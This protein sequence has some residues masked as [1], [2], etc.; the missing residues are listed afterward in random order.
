LSKNRKDQF[1]PLQAPRT[2]QND[3]GPGD[4]W[5][6]G[7]GRSKFPRKGRRDTKLGKTLPKHIQKNNL[8]PQS[9]QEVGGKTAP[10]GKKTMTWH[11]LKERG[12]RVFPGKKESLGPELGGMNLCQLGQKRPYKKGQKSH[13]QSPTTNTLSEYCMKYH[14]GTGVLGAFRGKNF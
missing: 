5:V 7:G 8:N 13:F 1:G 3:R 14:H 11:L 10:K 6:G 9:W 4:A 12:V 2:R